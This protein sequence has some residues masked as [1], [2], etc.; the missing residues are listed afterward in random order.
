MQ[1]HKYLSGTN[2]IGLDHDRSKIKVN[3]LQSDMGSYSECRY[4]T[5]MQPTHG[6]TSERSWLDARGAQGRFACIFQRDELGPPDDADHRVDGKRGL[7]RRSLD[8]ESV[9]LGC[10]GLS[11]PNTGTLLAHPAGFGVG[12]GGP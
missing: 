1:I 12:V 11:S 3:R 8:T 5:R 2:D 10:Q 7:D 4:Q 9:A 6:S